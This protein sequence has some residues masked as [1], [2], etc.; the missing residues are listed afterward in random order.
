MTPPDVPAVPARYEVY[1]DPPDRYS[2]GTAVLWTSLV[3]L[4]F[5]FGGAAAGYVYLDEGGRGFA[6]GAGQLG[7]A[8]VGAGIGTLYEYSV[9]NAAGVQLSP[10]SIVVSPA[11]PLC[12]VATGL[13][14]LGW[15]GVDVARTTHWKNEHLRLWGAEGSL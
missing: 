1:G 7:A 14:Y 4:V 6:V 8:L 13:L 9:L 10:A 3:G 11:V 15:A 5:P 2:S 12:A